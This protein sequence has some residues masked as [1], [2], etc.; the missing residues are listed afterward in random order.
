[1]KKRW[2]LSLFTSAI[3]V[4]LGL[5]FL[6]R[7][8]S[9]D[10]LRQAGSIRIGYAVEAPYAFVSPDGSVTGEAP[11]I[12][13][14]MAAG[15]GIAR[16]EWRQMEFSE[17]IGAL[18]AD[19]ID[20]AAAGLFITSDR[21]ARVS[22]SVPTMAVRPALLVARGNPKAVASYEQAARSGAHMAVLEGSMEQQILLRLGV[23]AAHI[24]VVP[25][26]LT[27]QHA[28]ES[29]L[30]DALLLSEPTLLWMARQDQL[31][32]TDLLVPRRGRG[33]DDNYG[34]PAFA[35]RRDATQLRSAWN[36]VLVPYLGSSDHRA[37]LMSL[38]L[39]DLATL[40]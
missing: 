38:G 3:L 1:M 22:F 29:G 8:H 19:R 11:E 18:Q 35:F 17:L 30:A 6:G 20:V 21:E 15:L 37:L 32:R 2:R 14:R 25:D 24:L 40:K 34:H 28:V 5:L 16:V 31:G 10:R 13:R 36:S 12:A 27:G 33:A 39:G 9:L 7:D 26:A 4:L 23:P